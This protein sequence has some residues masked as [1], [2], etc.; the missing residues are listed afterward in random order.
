MKT[1]RKDIRGLEPH[2]LNV[3]EQHAKEEGVTSN[4]L[5]REVITDYARRIEEDNA[6]KTLHSYIDDLIMANNNVVHGLN[7]NTLVIG[8]MFKTILAR[9]EMYFPELNDEVARIQKKASPQEK[10]FPTSINFDELN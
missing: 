6:S 2:V 5:L 1:V 9:L 8:E 7:E 10:N 3:I 4:D